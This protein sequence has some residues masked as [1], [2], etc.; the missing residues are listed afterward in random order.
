VPPWDDSLRE[1]LPSWDDY[2]VL[3]DYLDFIFDG[4]PE[5]GPERADPA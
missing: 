2:S 3:D 4:I 5:T 1:I